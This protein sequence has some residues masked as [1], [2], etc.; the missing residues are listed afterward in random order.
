MSVASKPP[1]LLGASRTALVIELE[2]PALGSAAWFAGAIMVLHSLGV[3][4]QA[5]IGY[6]SFMEMLE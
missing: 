5:A 3:S 6:L 2:M 4:V 1:L